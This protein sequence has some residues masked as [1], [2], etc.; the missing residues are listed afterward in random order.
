MFDNL[1]LTGHEEH[2]STI[3]LSAKKI[4]HGSF[5][6]L[7]QGAVEFAVAPRA[8][9][10]TPKGSMHSEMCEICIVPMVVAGAVLQAQQRHLSLSGLINP[11]TVPRF[12][13]F[14]LR[15]QPFRIPACNSCIREGIAITNSPS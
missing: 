13:V 12:F 7:Y 1:S 11:A 14:F 10:V 4:L 6:P 3:Q 9:S 15:K 5:Q 2:I 8:L